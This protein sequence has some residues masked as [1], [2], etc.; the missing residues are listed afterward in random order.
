MANLEFLPRVIWDNVP[1]HL[2]FSY[3]KAKILVVMQENIFFI[4]AGVENV[5]IR[6]TDSQGAENG[7]WELKNNGE[8]AALLEGAGLLVLLRSDDARLFVSGKLAKVFI[9]QVGRGQE[10]SQAA[11]IWAAGKSLAKKSRG[12]IGIIDLSASGYTLIAVSASGGLVDDFLINNPRCGAGSGTN[13]SRVLQ[14]L[15]IKR[16]EVDKIL[17]EYI[18]TEVKEKRQAINVRADRCGVFSSSATISDKNQGIPL[19]YALATTLKSEV[20]KACRKMIGKV[21]TVYLSGGVFTWR[22][23]RECAADHFQE[24]GISIELVED[25]GLLLDGIATLVKEIGADGFRTA[26]PKLRREKAL[27]TYKSF[28]ELEHELNDK[29]AYIRYPSLKPILPTNISD[30]PVDIGLDIG[31]TMAKVAI[32]PCGSEDAIYLGSFDNHGDTIETVKNIFKE[33][34]DN[35]LRELIVERIGITGSGRYQVQKVLSETYPELAGRIEVLVEN[36]AHARGSIRFARERIAE[37]AAKGHTVNK[38]RFVLVDVGGEDTKISIVSLK[39]ND[40]YDNAMN[41]KCSA[42]TGSLMDTLRAM[43]G[44]DDVRQAAIQAMAAEKSYAINAT[45]AVF[46]MENARKLQAAGYPQG[47]ILA[48]CYR[49][50][51]ENMARTLWPQVDFPENCLVL[52]HGQTMLSDPL[53]LA[54]IERFREYVTGA[55]YG[56]I[57]PFPGHRACLGLIAG[58]A[59]QAPSGKKIALTRL[60]TRHFE[61]RLFVCRGAACGDSR[62]A[63][64][65]SMLSYTDNGGQKKVILLGGCTSVNE[66]DA[67]RDSGKAEGRRLDVYQNIWTLADTAQPKSDDPRRLVIPRSFAVS[68]QSHFIAKIF[69]N[70]GIPVHVDSVKSE[71]VLLAQPGFDIDTCAPVIGAS[72]QFIRLATQAHGLIMGIVIDYLDTDGKSLGRTCTTNQGGIIIAIEKAKAKKPNA[73]FCSLNLDLKDKDPERLSIELE[74]K[75]KEVWQFYGINPDRAALEKAIG[76]AVREDDKLK[77]SLA[78]AAAAHI[79]QALSDDSPILISAGRE[80]ILNPGV[81]DSHIGKLFGEKGVCVI[82][83]WVLGVSLETEF[84]DIYWRNP[85]SIL[86]IVRLIRDRR[87]A[88]GIKNRNLQLAIEEAEKDTSSRIG[89]AIVSTFRCGPDS[90]IMPIIQEVAKDIPFLVIQSDAAIN[91]LAH[92]ENRVNTYLKQLAAGQSAYSGLDFRFSILEDFSEGSIDKEKDALYFPTIDDNRLLVSALRSGG[93]SCLDT[94]DREMHDLGALVSAGRRL[95]GDSVCAPFAAVLADTFRAAEDFIIRKSHGELADC[96]RVLVFNNRGS[97]PCRQGQYFNT[98][99][100]FLERELRKFATA[101]IE[102]HKAPIK[103]FELRYIVGLEKNNYNIGLSPQLLAK[104]F[105]STIVHGVLHGLLFQSSMIAKDWQESERYLVELKSLEDS[106]IA[107]FGKHHAGKTG[108]WAISRSIRQTNSEVS[109]ALEAFRKAWP[110]RAAEPRLRIYAEGEAYMRVAMAPEIYKAIFDLLGPGTFGFSYSPIWLYFEYIMEN[111]IL[112]I[113]DMY[114]SGEISNTT[115]RYRILKQKIAIT[116]FRLLIAKPFY[117]ASGLSFP[118]KMSDILNKARRVLPDLKPRGEL[119][120]YVGEGISKLEE[121]YDIYLNVAPEGCMVATMGEILAASIK[122]AATSAKPSSRLQGI[123]SADGELDE[124]KLETVIL[125]VLGPT[126]YYQKL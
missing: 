64:A 98:H 75:A 105:Q 14:K 9:S 88:S 68:E 112:D 30:I 87:L 58:L 111:K 23:A 4:D 108:I 104:A 48:S 2:F 5:R 95:A 8:L 102:K 31:S 34:A 32:T 59:P 113:E 71:D 54:T 11:A 22:F 106:L 109:R 119:A 118:G 12:N 47:E 124:E 18:G 100:V 20:L 125:K 21:D 74:K 35:G 10:V 26:S 90:M 86:S 17:A 63:C 114:R 81:Y 82:P 38:E 42:G 66:L 69:Q 41:V 107:I 40:L 84:N 72:G 103:S 99:R 56:A 29:D 93:Y 117:K 96:H 62:A 39:D 28:S 91:E 45:C 78:E 79:R 65:R 101:L 36:Y 55:A 50:I 60:T 6:K 85:H 80:Y 16:E 115:R 121:G 97:G 76:L 123:F 120:P 15:D 116:M 33:L 122:K 89:L 7:Y 27:P 46:L 51:V 70:L 1:I 13:L 67:A 43:F 77:D 94:F 73:R 92:L 37:L 110:A 3:K 19:A 44:V 24:A 25:G 126:A 61:K 53:P 83:S 52:L 57:P 49:A